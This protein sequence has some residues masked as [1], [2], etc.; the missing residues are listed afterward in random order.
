M[1]ADTRY[2]VGQTWT[3]ADA[4]QPETRTVIGALDELDGLGI[5]VSVSVIN[6]PVVHPKTGETQMHDIQ[7]APMLPEALDSCLLEQQ[8]KAYLAPLFE[9]LRQQWLEAVRTDG[10][11]AFSVSVAE[12]I[13]MYQPV[14]EQSLSS[15]P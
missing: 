9:K 5:V 2:A 3:F 12:L 1:V 6:F 13:S 8:E 11:G 7:H 14:I 10:A 4:P 15:E